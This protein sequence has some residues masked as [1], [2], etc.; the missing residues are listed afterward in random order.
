MLMRIFRWRA[1]CGPPEAAGFFTQH[2]RFAFYGA[3]ERAKDTSIRPTPSAKVRAKSTSLIAKGDFQDAPH[4][5]LSIYDGTDRIGMVIERHG[6][7]DAFDV[8][9]NH[10]GEFKKRKAA[11]DAVSLSAV[12]SCVPDTNGNGRRDNSE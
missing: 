11:A 7:C 10:L 2:S 5:H 12:S 1:C 8:H 9:G 4:R 3:Q 6:R